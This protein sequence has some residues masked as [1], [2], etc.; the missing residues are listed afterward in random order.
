VQTPETAQAPLM[1]R[2]ALQAVPSARVLGLGEMVHVFGSG[3]LTSNASMEA[4]D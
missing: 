4:H 3:V 2:A 1:P